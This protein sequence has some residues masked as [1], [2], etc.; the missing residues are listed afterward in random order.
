MTL[1]E[2]LPGVLQRGENS[3]TNFF[4]TGLEGVGAW[5]APAGWAPKHYTPGVWSVWGTPKRAIFPSRCLRHPDFSGVGAIILPTH[6]LKQKAVCFSGLEADNRLM[7]PARSFCAPIG[8]KPSADPTVCC[9]IWVARWT[10]GLNSTGAQ[11]LPARLIN[12]K[13]E[14]KAQRLGAGAA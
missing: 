5:G 3:G 9:S 12:T 6:P 11:T 8:Q 10:L 4:L 1:D 13:S 14:I 7:P 2:S